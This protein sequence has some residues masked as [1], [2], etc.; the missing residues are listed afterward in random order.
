MTVIT[1]LG[2]QLGGQPEWQDLQPGTRF[3]LAFP[4]REANLREEA[5]DP[6]TLSS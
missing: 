3:V 6:D 2:R 5:E 1:G 4:Y